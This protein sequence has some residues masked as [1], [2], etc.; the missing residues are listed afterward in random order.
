[1]ALFFFFG[2]IG[3]AIVN[4]FAIRAI[5]A[6]AGY[7]PTWAYV[8][9]IPYAIAVIGFLVVAADAK[10]GNPVEALENLAVVYI[11]LSLAA[12]GDWVLFL[13]FAFSA[14][15]NIPSK[16]DTWKAATKAKEVERTTLRMARSATVPSVDVPSTPAPLG[17]VTA[18]DAGAVTTPDLPPHPLTRSSNPPPENA[19]PPQ[20]VYC[21]RCGVA[22][23]EAGAFFHDCPS[24]AATPAFC[25][26]CGVAVEPDATACAGGH[27]VAP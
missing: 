1:M 25:R 14:W 7:S 22:M 19:A 15:P 27:S 20:V 21:A 8:T 18:E 11:L 26:E 5:V 6:K 12:F 9:Q 3:V 10:G 17:D 4:F 16:Y 2:G 23:D 24:G 13:V